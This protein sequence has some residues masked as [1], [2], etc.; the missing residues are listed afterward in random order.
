MIL[1]PKSVQQDQSK[2][3]LFKMDHADKAEG[4]WVQDEDM[5]LNL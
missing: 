5:K 1:P 2:A 4:E 3:E